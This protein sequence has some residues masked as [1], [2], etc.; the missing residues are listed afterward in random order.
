MLA[1][2][3][4]S[5]NRAQILKD[6]EVDGVQNHFHMAVRKAELS[7]V[8]MK[9]PEDKVVREHVLPN[10]I[11]ILKLA[12]ARNLSVDA[13]SNVLRRPAANGCRRTLPDSARRPLE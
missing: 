8:R 1:I 5:S 13:V 12:R 9:A 7:A 6:S 2:D 11:A 3:F 10:T 4:A